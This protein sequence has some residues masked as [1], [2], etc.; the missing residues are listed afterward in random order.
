MVLKNLRILALWTK[1]A[2]ALVKYDD[3]EEVE[4]GDVFFFEKFFVYC[5]SQTNKQTYHLIL[6]TN[7][8]IKEIQY[9]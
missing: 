4:N 3:E 9:K 6:H 2:P 8:M 1:V 5:I 7:R